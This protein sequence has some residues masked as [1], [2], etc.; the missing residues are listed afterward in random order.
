MAEPIN[1]VKETQI[2]FLFVHSGQLRQDQVEKILENCIKNLHERHGTKKCDYIVVTVAEKNGIHFGHSYAGVGD[3]KV[4]YALIGKNLDGS[5]RVDYID[6]PDYVKKEE[7]ED[8]DFDEDMNWDDIE[9]EEEKIPKKKIVLEPL[10]V[11]PP[12]KYTDEQYKKALEVAEAEA[13]KNNEPFDPKS[14][15][16]LGFVKFNNALVTIDS[17]FINSIYSNDIPYWITE[18]DLFNHFHRFSEDL[19]LH[20]DKATGKKFKYPLIR[21]TER[22]KVYGSDGDWRSVSKNGKT[23][24]CKTCEIKFSPLNK[25]AFFV[26]NISRRIPFKNKQ[27]GEETILFFS[28]SK[29][30]NRERNV[31]EYK[32]KR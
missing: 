2:G 26:Y 24:M 20:T 4:F 10:I 5:D 21:F 23:G 6:D 12:I 29:A 8:F 17:N 14:V 7:N 22:K 13:I 15:P 28:Q 3:K 25:D 19:T 11:P 27:T 30:R 9:D 31:S 1:K 18:K 16:K 32:K